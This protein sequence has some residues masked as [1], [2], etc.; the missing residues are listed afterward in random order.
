MRQIT[1]RELRGWH[2]LHTVG[3]ILLIG[4][5]VLMVAMAAAVLIVEGV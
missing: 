1:D 5:L 4:G 3:M 2:L